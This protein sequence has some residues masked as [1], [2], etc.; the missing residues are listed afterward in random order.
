MLRFEDFH[1]LRTEL[2]FG[3]QFRHSGSPFLSFLVQ[4]YQLRL[5]SRQATER[6]LAGSNLGIFRLDVAFHSRE[7]FLR[8]LEGL[9]EDFQSEELLEH[10]EAFRATRG[11]EL[12]HLLLPD[13]GRVPEPIIVQ[14]DDVADRA[15]LVRDRPLDGFP[16]SAYFQVGLFLRREAAG[17]LPPLV[18]LVERDPDIAIRPADVGQLHALDVRPG[19]LAVQG[20]SD[21]VEDRRL[22]RPG[23]A[24]DHRVFL[25]ESKRRH[26][27]LEVAHEAAHL[28]LLED[29]TFRT[30]R[31]FEAHDR[32]GLHVRVV[33]HVRVSLSSRRASTLIASRFGWA[34]R[35]FSV[36]SSP[37]PTAVS[38]L[39]IGLAGSSMKDQP[40]SG[41]IERNP[42]GSSR[43]PQSI[44]SGAPAYTIFP[45]TVWC[46]WMW[47]NTTRSTASG[48][49]SGVKVKSFG[50]TS[51]GAVLAYRTP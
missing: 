20:E 28:D 4:A 21:R 30:R 32:G 1:L 24:R 10:R 38:T 48:I 22:A 17:D 41:R 42:F 44:R 50:T 35:T 27:L 45:P 14:A 5:Q 37:M 7:S 12:L 3:L 2:E 15:L 29:E 49:I 47:P 39:S 33:S 18:A 36:T 34:A 40:P 26:R 51:E 19:R 23:P 25:R 46:I 9:F 8:P 43:S 6:F 11:P 16:V 31:R 13:E